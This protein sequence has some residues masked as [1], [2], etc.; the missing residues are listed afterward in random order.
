MMRPQAGAAR[1]PLV[2]WALFLVPALTVVLGVVLIVAVFR[3]SPHDSAA[4]RAFAGDRSCGSDLTT[5]PPI[6]DGNCT[7]VD[8]AVVRADLS[9]SSRTGTRAMSMT[10]HVVLRLATGTQLAAN[11]PGA[12][13]RTFV[14]RVY[15]GTTARAQL[16][17]GRLVRVWENGLTAETD[18]AP[19]VMAASDAT[20]P[21]VGGGMV[22]FGVL[23]GLLVRW[24]VRRFSG[25]S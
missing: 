19:D 13:G 2:L 7:V 8:A 1:Y 22:V 23:A 5:V 20:L 12:D 24:N 25:A 6:G 17:A 9:A 21:W 3:E 15:P 16:F 11:L 10:P 4:A 14:N 18:L